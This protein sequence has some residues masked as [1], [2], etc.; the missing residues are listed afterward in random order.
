MNFTLQKA[1]IIIAC[2]NIVLFVGGVRVIEDN[3]VLNNFINMDDYNDNNTIT[4]SDDFRG[5]VPENF[6]NTGATEGLSFIDVLRAVSGF[7]IFMVNIIFTPIGLFATLPS[8]VGLMV[9]VPLL[10]ATV[11]SLLYFVRS[12]R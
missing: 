2:L 6:E 9:G 12:G 5:S 11:I 3:N 8:I 7:I 1:I 4:V 10:I